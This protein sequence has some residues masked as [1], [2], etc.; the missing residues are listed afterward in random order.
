MNPVHR[1][2]LAR[3]ESL[4]THTVYHPWAIV[5]ILADTGVEA[6]VGRAGNSVIVLG[7]EIDKVEP[8]L[9]EPGIS[10][11]S[12]IRV[13]YEAIVGQPV[14]S[15][16]VGRGFWYRDVLSQLRNAEES[17]AWLTHALIPLEGPDLFYS[18]FA[19]QL[20][21]VFSAKPEVTLQDLK[22]RHRDLT[23]K[24]ITDW[25]GRAVEADLIER[26]GRSHRY[27]LKAE[28]RAQQSLFDSEES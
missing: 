2:L 14:K 11:Q 12:V 15:D 17:G 10:P 1:L 22:I 19:K 9:G 24:Q 27:T 3:L 16:M 18:Y 6:V 7:R 13:L 25:L 5:K 23:A 21:D 26:R 20:E 4:N 28:S 8:E